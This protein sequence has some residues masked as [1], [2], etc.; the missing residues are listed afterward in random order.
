M[1][2]IQMY[3]CAEGVAALREFAQ[4]IPV[5]VQ[6]IQESTQKLLQVYS[7]VSD[8]L[9]VHDSNFLEI[10][11]CVKR[12]QETAA[13]AVQELPPKLEQTATNIEAYISA[14]SSLN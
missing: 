3:L 8:E 4:A 14:G 2:G 9:G 12:A 10:L 7:S 11:Q 6:N 13:D 1:A 5:A